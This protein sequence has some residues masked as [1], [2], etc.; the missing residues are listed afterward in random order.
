MSIKKIV[1]FTLLVLLFGFVGRGNA[2]PIFA[3]EMF[4]DIPGVEKM[5]WRCDEGATLVAMYSKANEWWRSLTIT[6]IKIFAV[7]SKT[8]GAVRY[9]TAL[10]GEAQLHEVSAEQYKSDLAF[11]SSNYAKRLR[12]EPSDCVK[13]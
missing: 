1:G 11:A 10:H 6:N 13:M 12:G 2:E 8:G 9:F 3:S 7:E 5:M 4:P